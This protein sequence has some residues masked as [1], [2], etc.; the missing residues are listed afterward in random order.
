MSKRPFI[1][2]G[3]QKAGTTALTQFLADHPEVHIPKIKEMHFFDMFGDDK[4]L[5]TRLTDDIRR[6]YRRLELALEAGDSQAG[7]MAEIQSIAQRFD[8]GHDPAKYRAMLA[9]C[10]EN[11]RTYGEFTP[12][13][14]AMPVEKL[15]R[16]PQMLDQPRVLFILRNPTDRFLSQA[17]HKASFLAR[18][19][20]ETSTD[21]VAM[22][23][24]RGFTTRSQYDVT[25]DHLDRILPA[26]DVFV[27]FFEHMIGPEAPQ[28]HA[29]VCTFLG[30]DTAPAAQIPAGRPAQQRPV[31]SDDRQAIV[32]HFADTYRAIKARVGT[33]PD[34]W[35][36]DLA[37]L[38]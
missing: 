10:P 2:I 35:E 17:S 13:Y 16:I 12:A 28:F 21:P 4:A 38:G 34:T 11:V 25:L 23:Q 9:E 30:I 7:I 27:G 24:R 26:K 6:R 20:Q 31:A 36:A 14:A 18:N 37:M 29:D 8:V 33:L 15:A 3:A 1:G 5:A 32:S 19:Q 22:L